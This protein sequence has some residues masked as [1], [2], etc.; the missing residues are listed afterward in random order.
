VKKLTYRLTSLAA[1]FLLVGAASSTTASAQTYVSGFVGVPAGG[2]SVE[3]QP[4]YGGSFG[5]LG[6]GLGFELDLGYTPDFFDTEDI[7]GVGTNL[8][9]IMGNLMI[10]PG[11]GSAFRPYL[12]V[13]GG[14]I[15]SDVSGLDDV[16]DDLSTNDFGINAGGGI[17]VFLNDNVA[18]RGDARYFRSLT[19]EDDNDFFDVDL[20]DF[21]F[22]RISAG[23]ALAF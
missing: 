6:G 21:N 19:D 20:G 3:R 11:R 2:D 22:W 16:F 9:T 7:S 23:V 13:G 15:R 17:F 8:T 10:A 4:T 1:A 18:I 5:T 14:L 12:T